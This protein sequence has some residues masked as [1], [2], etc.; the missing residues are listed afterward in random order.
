[1]DTIQNRKSEIRNQII[2]PVILPV[3]ERVKAFKPRERVIFL[4]RH[5]RRA[6]A[7]SA[8]KSGI[9]LGD[10]LKDEN[11]APLPFENT[12][13]SVTH[14]PG[15]VGGVVAPQP[16]GIDIERIRPC[17]PALFR[18]TAAASEWALAAP[19]HDSPVIFFR[20]WT[21]KEAVLKA[22]R[23]GLK[24][25]SN[26]RIL[27]IIDDQHLLVENQE[28]TWPVEQYFFDGH[29]ASIVKETSRIEWSLLKAS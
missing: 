15:Y 23:T 3:P 28:R 4:S 21:S 13:W 14:K 24:D 2:Y 8:A 11:G 27:R 25:L 9:A 5:A 16:V 12:F 26:C 1:M 18:K 20:Y 10:L 17:S 6:V 7:I 19:D 29:I 22:S